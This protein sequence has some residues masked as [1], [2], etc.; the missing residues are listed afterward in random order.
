MAT[1]PKTKPAPLR[2]RVCSDDD[3]IAIR[4]F[5]REFGIRCVIDIDPTRPE[6]TRALDKALAR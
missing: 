1:N 3:A 5:C 2:V 6:D 4:A